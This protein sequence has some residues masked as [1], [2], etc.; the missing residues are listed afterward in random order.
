MN[1]WWVWSDDRGQRPIS[2]PFAIIDPID[3]L[4]A[5]FVRKIA[6]IMNGLIASD[7]LLLAHDYRFRFN[8]TFLAGKQ[9]YKKGSGSSANP[10]HL[11]KHSLLDFP[12][13]D[14]VTIWKFTITMT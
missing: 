5:S 2:A 3:A 6:L 7:G 1:T 8:N 13:H 14:I 11:P 9:A 12:T 4:Y 10:L